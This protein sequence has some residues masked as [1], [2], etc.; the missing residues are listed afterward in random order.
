MNDT[1]KFTMQQ[2]LDAGV[3]FG[4][5][6]MRWDPRMA[7][8][9]YGERN[10]VHIIDLQKT[11][12][13][14]Y[15]ALEKA[16]DVAK[17]GGKILFVSTKRQA[18]NIVK[19]AAELCGQYYVNHRWLGGMLTNWSTVSQSIKTLQELETQLQDPD[20]VISKKERLQI[21][22]RINKL[23]LA[24]GGIKEMG[25]VPDLIFVI[26]TKKEKIAIDEA[27]KLGIP[28][29]GIVDSNANPEH[30]DYVVPGNDDAIRAI[31]LYCNLMAD[32]VLGGIQQSVG[33]VEPLKKEAAPTESDE[34]KVEVK[35]AKKKT[36]KPSENKDEA[37]KTEEENAPV[38]KAASGS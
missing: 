6:T 38:V 10:G 33:K 3:H 12:P 36:E 37:E 28:V 17:S 29:I 30:I 8:Y 9:I 26:D 35:A 32:A 7:P 4:H 23:E 20:I 13:L 24:L 34:T 1:I 5:K 15:R 16:Q 21:H 31:Q 11:V 25:G 2:L 14:L 18:S 19:E 22:R 27:N